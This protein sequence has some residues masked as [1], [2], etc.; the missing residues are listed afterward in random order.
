MLRSIVT[1]YNPWIFFD[2][3]LFTLGLSWKEWGVLLVSILI[4]MYVEKLQQSIC[5]R[6]RVLAQPLLIRW[7]IYL[8][9]VAAIMI[10]GT[11]GFGF[12]A[13]DFIYGGF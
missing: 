5:I 2:D 10:F 3:S 12:T 8:G 11:Y 6:D 1:V 13:S 4:L 9:A 7:G